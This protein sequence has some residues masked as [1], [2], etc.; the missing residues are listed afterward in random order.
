MKLEP[1]VMPKPSPLLD[2][3]R[4]LSPYILP[5]HAAT[6]SASRSPEPPWRRPLKSKNE[7]SLDP[8]TLFTTSKKLSPGLLTAFNLEYAESSNEMVLVPMHLCICIHT[9]NHYAHLE[10]STKICAVTR[11]VRA[12]KI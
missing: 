5:L 8:S 6:I 10:S 1:T 11:Y 12:N 9:L 3:T 2:N 7:G 4:S